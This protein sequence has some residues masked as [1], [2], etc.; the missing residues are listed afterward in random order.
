[1]LH[2][3]SPAWP[4]CGSDVLWKQSIRV[5]IRTLCIRVRVRVSFRARVRVLHI[6]LGIFVFSDL[7]SQVIGELLIK[8][9]SLIVTL[10]NCTVLALSACISHTGSGLNHW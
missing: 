4:Q 7:F 2:Q 10:F 1:M 5:T 3:A 8:S 9:A 6:G